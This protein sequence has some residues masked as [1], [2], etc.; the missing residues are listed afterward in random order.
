MKKLLLL[1]A[2][3][4]PFCSAHCQT[5]SDSLLIG[6]WS[7]VIPASDSVFGYWMSEYSY[8]FY[9]GG[10][11]QQKTVFVQ[12]MRG[13]IEATTTTEI[14][15]KWKIKNG[16][17]ELTEKHAIP[18][19]HYPK[20]ERSNESLKFLLKG[21]DSL[22]FLSF[23]EDQQS[24]FLRAPAR[25]H[26]IDT[27]PMPQAGFFII[28]RLDKKKY[29][30]YESDQSPGALSIT[31]KPDT[32]TENTYKGSLSV[33]DTTSFT[34]KLSSST[35]IKKSSQSGTYQKCEEQKVYNFRDT[36]FQKFSYR[37]NFDLGI[38]WTN[39][40]NTGNVFFGF[41]AVTSAFSAFVIAP[42]ISVKYSNGDFNKQ[43]Y[44]RTA[45][46]SLALMT[47]CIPI[48]NR[49]S[50]NATPGGFDIDDDHW[51][52]SKNPPYPGAKLKR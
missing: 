38:Y 4:S 48:T 52:L 34:L 18:Y 17:L 37:D 2:I 31:Q 47:I 23:Y 3:T 22:Y 25:P 21:T 29:Y 39:P 8:H 45:L 46:G 7:Q 16:K 50:D 1:V 30:F 36:V 24:A 28:N 12:K 35:T 33:S 26:I 32:S 43:R 44:Y 51:Y 40:K 49:L 10:I 6:S 13:H 15:G 5:L 19:S 42:L 27:Y 41:L 20:E 9:P 14:G 11:F